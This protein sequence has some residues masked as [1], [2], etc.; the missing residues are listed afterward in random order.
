MMI[1]FTATRDGKTIIGLGLSKRNLELLLQDR[2]IIVKLSDL[3]LPWRGE[4]FI[5]AD[6]TEEVM[7]EKLKSLGLI[8]EQTN[9]IGDHGNTEQ[10]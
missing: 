8:S 4:I 10:H 3:G 1:K 7:F 6:E 9:I 2:P 5:M